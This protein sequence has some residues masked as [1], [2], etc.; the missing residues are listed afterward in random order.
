MLRKELPSSRDS[1]PVTNE[2]IVDLVCGWYAGY[3]TRLVCWLGEVPNEIMNRISKFALA[4]LK[5]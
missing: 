2:A 4:R 3:E 5:Q 1:S